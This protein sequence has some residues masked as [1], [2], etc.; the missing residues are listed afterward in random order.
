MLLNKH[1]GKYNKGG[2]I[3]PFYREYKEEKMKIENKSKNRIAYHDKN[4]VLQIIGIGEIAEV[5]D[6]IA[7]LILRFDGVREY[8]EPKDVKRLE[9]ENAKL[10]AQLEN[11]T[12]SLDELKAEADALGIKYAKNIGAKKLQQKIDEFKAE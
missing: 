12:K 8:A 10:K 9:E 6:E 1:K 2:F 3:P 11:K 7:K 4:K 5:D